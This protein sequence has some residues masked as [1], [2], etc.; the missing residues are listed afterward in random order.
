MKKSSSSKELLIDWLRTALD[1]QM[2]PG[3]AWS[4]RREEIFSV[5]WVHKSSEQWS[6]DDLAPFRAWAA[7][8]GNFNKNVL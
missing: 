8:K 6:G 1:Y 4:D 5:K 2:Y 3:L 7:H